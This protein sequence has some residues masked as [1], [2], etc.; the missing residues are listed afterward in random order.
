MVVAGEL[1]LPQELLTR[2]RLTLG[3]LIAIERGPL[4]VR[5]DLYR[6]F[7]DSDWEGLSPETARHLVEEY[8]C[9]PLTA[10]LPG[11]RLPFPHEVLPLAIGDRLV[12]QVRAT[13]LH[14]ELVLFRAGADV[15]T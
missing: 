10:I 15:G 7:L 3:D 9:Q 8:L 14:H 11:G 6:D 1:T 12:L 13:G 4:S 5:L 2:L